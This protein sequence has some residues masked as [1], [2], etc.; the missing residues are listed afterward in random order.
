MLRLEK[1]TVLDGSIGLI[2]PNPTIV[3]VADKV[4]LI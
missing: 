2:W 3:K 1:V 4:T